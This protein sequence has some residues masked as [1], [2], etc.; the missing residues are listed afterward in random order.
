MSAQPTDEVLLNY[1][2]VGAAMG[3]PPVIIRSDVK[4]R[5]SAK[6]NYSIVT[7]RADAKAML[8]IL[9]AV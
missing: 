7:G 3:R 2:P 6:K 9:N 1:A 5:A 4:Q 8:A